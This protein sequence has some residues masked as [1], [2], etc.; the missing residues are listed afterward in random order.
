MKKIIFL[1]TILLL[2]SGCTYVGRH[3]PPINTDKL[4]FAFYTWLFNLQLVID[5]EITSD[6]AGGRSRYVAHPHSS[7][8][9][10]SYT[11]LIF[12]HSKE[13]AQGFPD[14]VIV[15]W[16]ADTSHTHAAMHTF[17]LSVMRPAEELS[18][19]EPIILEDFGLTYPITIAD[20]VDNWEAVV[21]VWL[22][23]TDSEQIGIRWPPRLPSDYY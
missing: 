4:D 5:G 1:T 9:D 6:P 14:N 19:R 15:A 22:E 17:N 10:R 3:N 12:F 20:L 8:F 21:N 23:L 18:R 2:I 16:P 7:G 13:E 11:E